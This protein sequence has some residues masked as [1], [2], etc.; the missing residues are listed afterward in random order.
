MPGLS[1]DRVSLLGERGRAVD[2]FACPIDFLIAD[3]PVTGPG[4]LSR[5]GVRITDQV[6][7]KRVADQL[8]ALA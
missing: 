7:A 6:A 5:H 3:P 8:P 2:G 1:D 4:S